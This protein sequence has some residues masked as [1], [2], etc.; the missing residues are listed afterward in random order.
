LED[1]LYWVM[2]HKDECKGCD[3]DMAALRALAD[4][5][6]SVFCIEMAALVEMGHSNKCSRE[7]SDHLVEC[8]RCARIGQYVANMPSEGKV[9]VRPLSL[10]A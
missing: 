4:K 6:P 1:D 10:T 9:E 8:M 3:E 5:A 7:E 2:R